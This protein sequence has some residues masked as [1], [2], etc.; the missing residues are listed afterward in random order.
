MKAL[1]ETGWIK[2]YLSDL[3]DMLE[4]ENTMSGTLLDITGQSYLKSVSNILKVFSTFPGIS[5]CLEYEETCTFD[6][7]TLSHVIN[8]LVL[9]DK[10]EILDLICFEESH[11]TGS[12]LI[13]I[14]LLI[15]SQ[16]TQSLDSTILLN[17]KF[18]FQDAL[19]RLHLDS[20]IQTCKYRFIKC[21][22][23]TNGHLSLMKIHCYVTQF[24]YHVW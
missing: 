6:K 18:Q 1:C 11:Y 20:R 13:I 22:H 3:L 2:L 19:V 9:V 8:S 14:G 10:N 21:Q 23:P 16:L 17:L 24:F 15:L 12:S 5:S 7:G 4:F